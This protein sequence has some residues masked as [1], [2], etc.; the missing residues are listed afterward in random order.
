VVK[1]MAALHYDVSS[2]QIIRHIEISD[3]LVDIRIGV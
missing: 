3:R 2:T 1:V